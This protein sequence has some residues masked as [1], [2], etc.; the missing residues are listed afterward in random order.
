M[1]RAEWLALAGIVVASGASWPLLGTASAGPG[2]VVRAI[3]RLAANEV[4]ALVR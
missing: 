4:A 3:D 1:R 2:P